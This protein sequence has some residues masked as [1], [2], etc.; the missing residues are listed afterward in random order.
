[1]VKL[2][3]P[4]LGPILDGSVTPDEA[5]AE[6]RRHL[7]EFEPDHRWCIPWS[8]VLWQRG[9]YDEAYAVAS[10]HHSALHN[11]DDFLLLF[12]MIARQ[13]P[14][15]LA[16]AEAAF[17][18]ALQLNP[19]R[20]DTYYNLGNLY[21]FQERFDEAI[22]EYRL[23][24]GLNPNSALTWLNYGLAARGKD[25][26]LLSEI[27][28][29]RSLALDPESIRA[30]C[31]YGITCHQLEK[32]DQAIKCYYRALSLDAEHGPSL[33][34]LGQ[35]LNA[36][37]RHPEAVEYLQAA[38]SL[39]LQE[40]SGDALFNLALTRLLLGDYK[41][42]WELYE[43]RFK[44][45]Q[46]DVYSRIPR[47][48]WIQC[49]DRLRQLASE[50]AEV[51]VWSEQGLGDAIQFVRYLYL[52]KS[53]GLRPILATRPLLVR[54]FQDWLQP[55]VLVIDDVQV[56]IRNDQRPHLAMLSL[57]HLIGTT[58]STIP[59]ILPYLHPPGP[60]PEALLVSE[61]SGGLS[62]GLVWASNPDNKLMYRRKSLPLSQLLEPL[63][64]AL[65]EDLIALHC[66]QV[67]QDAEDLEPYI[68]HPNIIN[69][70]GRLGDFADTAHVVRQLD[71][72]ICVDTG[73]AHLASALGVPTWLMLHYDSDFRW[74]RN[75]EF[76]PWY[77]NM[78]LF[79]Q[80]GYGDWGS[81]VRSVVDEL[82]FIY[83]LDLLSLR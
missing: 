73:V 60:S 12:G 9:D 77:P 47:G 67:G 16:E 53:I 15:R 55:S 68:R 11:N 50:G 18:S 34:N 17:R 79:R 1:M 59:S 38:S 25:Q 39:T 14:N 7:Q 81:V 44:T 29:R 58:L 20:H 74:M 27:A 24:L 23:S 49:P 40:D 71:L 63:L 2:L 33:L 13:L 31:N 52:L 45:R 26:L 5:I 61:Q 80:A 42:G 8:F 83:G 3:E 4:V 66:L 10:A 57:P 75:C 21:F 51:L 19:A 78:K 64:P 54:L 37:N 62:V 6:A 48:E 72:V 69:W 46:H 41:K 82:G 35:A 56:D 32:F 22:H 30:W 43:C 65:R 76:S 70:N 28:L 36:S